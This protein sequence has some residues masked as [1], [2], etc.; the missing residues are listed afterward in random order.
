MTD[1]HSYI[2]VPLDDVARDN[3]VYWAGKVDYWE[4]NGLQEAVIA[5][6]TEERF[7]IVPLPE[8]GWK[9]E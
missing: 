5:T 3:V 6:K 8:S 4:T 9:I 7:A 2:K 1:S